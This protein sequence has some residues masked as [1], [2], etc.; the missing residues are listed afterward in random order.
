MWWAFWCKMAT[1]LH[2]GWCYTLVVV[3]PSL[4]PSLSSSLS[5]SDERHYINGINLL[6]ILVLVVVFYIYSNILPVLVLIVIVV[7]YTSYFDGWEW[8]EHV[9]RPGPGC[10]ALAWVFASPGWA[11][12][13]PHTGP[14]AH[15]W[16][17]PT[18]RRSDPPAAWWRTWQ[19]NKHK[20]AWSIVWCIHSQN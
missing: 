17:R 5:P 11:W 13:W 10:S 18:R 8:T 4:H 7:Y 6:L 16:G 1:V 3:E 9:S 15:C 19:E 14:P 12:K 20:R 2:T